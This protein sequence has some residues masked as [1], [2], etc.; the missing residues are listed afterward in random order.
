MMAETIKEEKDSRETKAK[1]DLKEKLKS[2][3]T[4]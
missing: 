1:I 3:G 2:L 4:P